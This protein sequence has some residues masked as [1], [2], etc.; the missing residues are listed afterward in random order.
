MKW[1]RLKQDFLKLKYIALLMIA[2]KVHPKHNVPSQLQMQRDLRSCS[3]KFG[4]LSKTLRVSGLA[5]A[6]QAR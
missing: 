2:N 1:Q 3:P 6:L 4:V 5:L